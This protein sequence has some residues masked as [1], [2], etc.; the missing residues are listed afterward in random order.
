MNPLS[1][2][3]KH[4]SSHQ[5]VGDAGRLHYLDFP[6]NHDEEKDSLVPNLDQHVPA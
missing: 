2:S 1:S 6:A 5:S 3:T 4:R